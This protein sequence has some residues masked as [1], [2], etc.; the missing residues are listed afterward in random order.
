MVMLALAGAVVAG[1]LS[2]CRQ[3]RPKVGPGGRSLEG[4]PVIRVRLA[5]PVEQ[6]T[7]AATGAY[8][9]RVEG[10]AVSESRGPLAPTSVRRSGGAWRINNLTS[11]GDTLTLVPGADSFVRL[12]SASFRGELQ[13]RAL[14]DGAFEVINHLDLESYLAGVLGR[15][16]Y[17][18]WDLE[19]YRALAVAAR[20][21][22]LYHMKT[23]GR[24]RSSDLGPGQAYQVYGGVAAESERSWA[25]VGD[26]RGR[27]LAY[28][29]KRSERI[30]MPQYSACNGGYVNGAYVIRAAQRIEPLEG[31]QRDDD[32]RSCPRFRWDPVTVGKAD[33]HRALIGSYKSARQLKDVRSIR[34]VEKTPYGRAVWLDVHDS[35][36]KSMRLRAED[37]RLV[38]LRSDIPNAR[39]LY[40]MNCR[41][42]D[43]GDAVEFY[44]GRGFGHGVGL[45]QWGAQDKARRGWKARQI[46]EFYYPGAA[47]IVVY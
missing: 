8:S 10:R 7:L 1:S 3:D 31:G 9:L 37:L 40:S 34:V 46:L 2:S 32:G 15:E 47:V 12:G 21:F 20:T 11:R 5:G 22:A 36:G 13:L 41:L 16:L 14:S 19:T 4:V 43:R 17:P 25:A 45:S 27:V 29:P 35:D 28:G 6:A 38:I 39:K 44:E 18:H 30:F 42:R 33:L 23:S 26:T 24:E